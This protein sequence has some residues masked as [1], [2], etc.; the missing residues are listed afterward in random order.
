MSK[1]VHSTSFLSS[2]VGSIQKAVIRESENALR[3]CTAV[4]Q[5]AGAALPVLM[6]ST[7]GMYPGAQVDAV[8]RVWA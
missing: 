3:F 6:S 2:V 4:H 1:A 8:P 5:A 7:A